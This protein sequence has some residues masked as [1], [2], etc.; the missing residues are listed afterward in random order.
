[1]VEHV[2]RGLSKLSIRDRARRTGLEAW[3][4]GQLFAFQRAPKGPEGIVFLGESGR[5]GPDDNP[6]TVEAIPPSVAPLFALFT[7]KDLYREGRDTVR[8]V[9]FAPALAGGKSPVEL[10]LN[11]Q[12]LT[13]I[14]LSFG[15]SGLGIYEYP[16]PVAGEYEVTAGAASTKFTVAEYKLAP[17]TARFDG[18]SVSTRGAVER[19]T[20]GAVLESYGTSFAG[21]V[22]IQVLDLS[23]TPGRVIGKIVATADG[24]GRIEGDVDLQGKGPFSLALAATDDVQKTAMLPI[25]GS[26]AEERA[27]LVLSRWGA[28]RVARQ[29]PFEGAS[30]LRG[31]YVAETPENDVITPLT[32]VASDRDHAIIRVEAKTAALR[33]VVFDPVTR[34]F[35]EHELGATAAGTELPIRL[36]RGPWSLVLAGMTYLGHHWEGR[37]AIVRPVAPPLNLRDPSASEPISLEIQ[38]KAEPG[39]RIELNIRGFPNGEA[40]VLVKDERL[41]VTDTLVASTASSLRRQ[42]TSALGAHPEGA[43]TASLAEVMMPPPPVPPMFGGLPEGMAIPRAMPMPSGPPRS[44]GVVS[45]ARP[46]VPPPA[47]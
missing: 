22:A 45:A 16:E 14:E 20:F 18:F 19:F 37:A 29:L 43:V 26:R 3:A 39:E 32:L 28:R 25:P 38:E 44:R 13:T 33:V 47:P 4:V 27:E 34:T 36:A 17:L 41:Q 31:L 40:F 35:D 21:T 46:A 42:L 1:M 15:R 6:V 8:I 5:F 24:N 7:D 12:A 23:T 10:R 11:G 9:G 30:E 2:V